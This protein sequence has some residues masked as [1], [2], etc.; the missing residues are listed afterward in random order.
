[1]TELKKVFN[2]HDI[3]FD[4]FYEKLDDVTIDS[5]SSDIDWNIVKKIRIRKRVRQFTIYKN[6]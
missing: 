6:R 1:M 3:P 5:L 2:K 4:R